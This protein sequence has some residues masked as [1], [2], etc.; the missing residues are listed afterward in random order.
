MNA[1]AGGEI[2]DGSIFHQ[3]RSQAKDIALFSNQG[4]EV[5]DINKLAQK[6]SSK[7]IFQTKQFNNPQSWSNL[8][9][10]WNQ[11]EWDFGANKKDATFQDDWSNKPLLLLRIWYVKIA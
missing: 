8:E 10:R 4:L 7:F 2:I 5:D 6:Y 3:T 11:S 1:E 9:L